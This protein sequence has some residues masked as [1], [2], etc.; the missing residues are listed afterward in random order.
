MPP[1]FL[2]IAVVT[3][4]NNA[5]QKKLSL[6]CPPR[7]NFL[8]TVVDMTDSCSTRRFVTVLDGFPVRS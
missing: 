7:Y 2:E 8:P 4:E 3:F 5:A 6:L 1:T